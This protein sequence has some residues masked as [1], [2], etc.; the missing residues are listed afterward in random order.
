MFLP[1]NLGPLFYAHWLV[2][3]KLGILEVITKG[4]GV[5]LLSVPAAVESFYNV[6]PVDHN[7]VNEV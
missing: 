5:W 6:W 7:Y 3:A 4:R 1:S 2:G